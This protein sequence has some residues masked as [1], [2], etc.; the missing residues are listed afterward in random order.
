MPL[1]GRRYLLAA[2]ALSS[3]LLGP[4]AL[5]SANSPLVLEHVTQED[6][7]SQSTVMDIVQDSQGFIWLA[8]ESG[9]NRYDGYAVR[10]YNRDRH[11]PAALRSDYIWQILEDGKGDLWLA[12]E[13]GGVARWSR[14]SDAF[15]SFVHDPEDPHSIASDNVRALAATPDGRIWVG[16][17]DGGLGL[18]DPSTGRVERYR[19]GRQRS[20]VAPWRV[21]I[22]PACRRPRPALGRHGQGSE[23]AGYR[24][25]AIHPLPPRSP[26]PP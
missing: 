9:L 5:A 12:T 18:L 1:A 10:S 3:L 6:G 15:T 25:W 7:L 20:R 16:T 14:R 2:V 17:R 21:G 11:D 22:F 8:T 23:P 26:G 13:G 19:Y 24:Q 4:L